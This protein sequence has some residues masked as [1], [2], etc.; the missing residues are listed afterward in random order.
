M[1][2]QDKILP[3]PLWYKYLPFVANGIAGQLPF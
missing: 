1:Q 3:L 2:K